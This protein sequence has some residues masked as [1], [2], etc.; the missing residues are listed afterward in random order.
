MIIELLKEDQNAACILIKVDGNIEKV[1][2][3]FSSRKKGYLDLAKCKKL[4]GCRY[5]QM[6]PLNFE[7]PEGKYEMLLDEEGRLNGA[8]YNHS[9]S[10]MLGT[11]TYG[12]MEMF[13]NVLL[14]KAG[15]LA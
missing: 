4:L 11:Q 10:S 5:I 2:E 8:E 3:P 6:V 14:F 1:L 12:G 7:V 15:A 13:G 9:A